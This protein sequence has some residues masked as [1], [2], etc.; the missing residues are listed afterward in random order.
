MM[1]SPS[2]VSSPS[3]SETSGAREKCELLT[4][5]GL[6]S[7]TRHS[8]MAQFGCPKSKDPLAFDAGTGGPPGNSKYTNIVTGDTVLRN[9]GGCIPDE[10]TA[11]FS[12][13]PGTLSMAN[14]G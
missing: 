11:K 3:E 2:T 8:F 13:E 4:L 12:N 6:L 9:G 5:P 1:D 14:T 7:R 10:F